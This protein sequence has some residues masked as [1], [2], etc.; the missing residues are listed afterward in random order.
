MKKR[1]GT[2][3]LDKIGMQPFM[4]I[5]LLEEAHEKKPVSDRPYSKYAKEL[6]VWAEPLR[7]T[8][9]VNDLMEMF[10]SSYKRSMR[11][12]GVVPSSGA[13]VQ[14]VDCLRRLGV[15]SNDWPRIALTVEGINQAILKKASRD[16][17]VLLGTSVMHL[18]LSSYAQEALERAFGRDREAITIG[19][20]VAVSQDWWSRHSNHNLTASIKTT[21][22]LLRTLGLKREDGIFLREYSKEW[23][24]DL[25]ARELEMSKKEATKIFDYFLAKGWR[26]RIEQ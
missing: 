25:I 12:R 2:R 6:S 11:R 17:V 19:Q 20:L 26:P 14:F 9:T 22:D 16:K 1:V 21:R 4:Q 24:L 23:Y 8:T 7:H 5:R 15:T 10:G 3:T 18:P 13:F